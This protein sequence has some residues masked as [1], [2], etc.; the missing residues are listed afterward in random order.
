MRE[1]AGEVAVTD[2]TADG[3]DLV[4]DDVRGAR[5]DAR[6]V[7]I[8]AIRLRRV[9]TLALARGEGQTYAPDQPDPEY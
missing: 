5:R 9:A 7:S 4:R 8:F 3:D 6:M 2:E 1:R